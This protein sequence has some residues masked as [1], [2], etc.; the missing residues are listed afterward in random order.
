MCF[1]KDFTAILNR[2]MCCFETLANG[3]E[4]DL[5]Q[6]M[7]NKEKRGMFARSKSEEKEPTLEIE[8]VD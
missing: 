8:H 3:N 7:R 1:L 6:Q 4:V 5:M 2:N